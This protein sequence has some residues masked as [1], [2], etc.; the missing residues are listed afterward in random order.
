[1]GTGTSRAKSTSAW[2]PFNLRQ[3]L[4]S[5]EGKIWQ[6]EDTLQIL[7]RAEQIDA[8]IE[9]LMR[10]A[11]VDVIESGPVPPESDH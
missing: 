2:I 1:M 8:L 10:A 4:E 5:R 6:Q 11:G 3:Y 9:Q 7:T